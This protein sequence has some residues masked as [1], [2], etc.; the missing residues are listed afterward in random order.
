MNELIYRSAIEL[1][2]QIRLKNPLSEEVVGS[3]L[4]RIAVVNPKLNAV[5]QLADKALEQAKQADS[6]LFRGD[7]S[8]PLHGVPFTA[9][10]V[11]DTAGI[12][13]AAALWTESPMSPQRM[14]R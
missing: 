3:C 13:S 14:P 9:K 8:G 7:V 12:V 5:T 6:A 11:F 10:D 4:Q 2:K 1:G